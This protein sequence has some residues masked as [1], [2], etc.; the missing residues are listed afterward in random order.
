LF[1]RIFFVCQK[2]NLINGQNLNDFVTNF[3]QNANFGEVRNEIANVV[4]ADFKSDR[5]VFESNGYLTFVDQH[6]HNVHL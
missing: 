3:K 1:L 2:H 5:V 4:F 6:I